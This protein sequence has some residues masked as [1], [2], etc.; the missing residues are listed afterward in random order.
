MPLAP[1]QHAHIAALTGVIKTWYSISILTLFEGLMGPG[2]K[3][4]FKKNHNIVETYRAFMYKVVE[5]ANVFK[6][7]Q[8]ITVIP[9]GIVFNSTTFL[10][11]PC[12]LFCHKA[13][14]QSIHSHQLRLLLSKLLW[15][16]FH[17]M[18]LWNPLVDL[19]CFLTYSKFT[20]NPSE[21]FWACCQLLGGVWKYY[22]CAPT[23][24]RWWWC[25]GVRTAATQLR[26][27]ILPL[28]EEEESFIT[29]RII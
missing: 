28:V 20:L 29:Y 13:G 1:E 23:R 7:L 17:I 14:R 15:Q 9:W 4:L 24:E 2:D 3:R 16:L 5:V 18:S 12:Y 21:R 27:L 25:D 11:S 8:F 19:H 10:T 26:S 22:D 6:T